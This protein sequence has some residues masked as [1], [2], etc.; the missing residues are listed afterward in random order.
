MTIAVDW[1][2]KHQTKQNKLGKANLP[3]PYNF[4]RCIFIVENRDFGAKR[5]PRLKPFQQYIFLYRDPGSEVINLF[6]A[7]LN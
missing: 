5:G 1:D 7:Q 2:V 3:M 4:K 6:S